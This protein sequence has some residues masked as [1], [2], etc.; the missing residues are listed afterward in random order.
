MKK[1][2]CNCP[3]FPGFY[4]SLY[5]SSDDTYYLIKEEIE[6]WKN[7]CGVELEGDDFNIDYR[8]RENDMCEGHAQVFKSYCPDFILDVRFKS[9]WSPAYY[10]YSTDEAI[11]EIEFDEDYLSYFESFIATNR[12]WLENKIQEDWGTYDGFISFIDN[13]LD[14]FVSHLYNPEDKDFDD[15]MCIMLTYYMY[16]TWE[17]ENPRAD[18]LRYKIQYET[19]DDYGSLNE[20]LEL[21]D[22]AKELIKNAE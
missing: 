14:S 5:Y 9:L 15:Y 2:T 11:V 1:I 19:Y 17:L 6:Y 4:E 10:N 22:R 16:R 7:E 13:G 20:Y 3:F 21:S 18:N 8:S 12:E